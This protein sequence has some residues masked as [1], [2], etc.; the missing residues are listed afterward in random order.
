MAQKPN[1]FEPAQANLENTV[2]DSS[3]TQKRE[4]T[5][6]SIAKIFI[7]GY[8]CIIILLIAATTLAKLAPDVAKD[9][10]LAISSPLG[11]VIGYYFKSVSDRE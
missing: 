9:Y 8:L 4:D 6:S 7:T 1:T 3:L 5:R 2:R 11:F 10:L